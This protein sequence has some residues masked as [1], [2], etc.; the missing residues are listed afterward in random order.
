MSTNPYGDEP[1]A[2]CPDCMAYMQRR[3]PA[4]LPLLA[5]RARTRA[6]TGKQE[7]GRY[8]RSVHD[9]H[10]AGLPIGATS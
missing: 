5:D 6:T 3:G 2:N 4:I 1:F 7:V 9:R 10:V 8:M